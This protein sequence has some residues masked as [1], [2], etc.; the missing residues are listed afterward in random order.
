MKVGPVV[1]GAVVIEIEAQIVGG[2]QS[3]IDRSKFADRVPIVVVGQ[4]GGQ[5]W[6]PR[7]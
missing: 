2:M 3:Q 4:A 5:A 1:G 6:W 7:W